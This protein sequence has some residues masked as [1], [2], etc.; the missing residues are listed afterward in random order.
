MALNK[1]WDLMGR[2]GTK[3]KESKMK[4]E[5]TETRTIREGQGKKLSAQRSKSTGSKKTGDRRGTSL[6]VGGASIGAPRLVRVRGAR[7]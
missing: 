2:E 7:A 1:P 4:Y 5:K 3:G 6:L